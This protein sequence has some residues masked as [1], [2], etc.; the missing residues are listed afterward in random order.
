MREVLVDSIHPVNRASFDLNFIHRLKR[1]GNRLLFT[2]EQSINNMIQNPLTYSTA[3]SSTVT[4]DT[5]CGPWRP[6][7]I[8]LLHFVIDNYIK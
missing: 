1:C 2:A 6:G 8:I 3:F 4:F 5:V 7:T